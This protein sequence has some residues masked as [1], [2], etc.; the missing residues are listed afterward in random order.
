MAGIPAVYTPSGGTPRDVTVI[1]SHGEN[2]ETD[3]IRH[4]GEAGATLEIQESEIP[5][6]AYQDQVE[7][8]GEIWTVAKRL[9]RTAGK[10]KLEIRRDLRPTFRRG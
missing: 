1:I 5:E 8:E 9:G 7:V 3:R 10:W 6:P 4:A 2:P